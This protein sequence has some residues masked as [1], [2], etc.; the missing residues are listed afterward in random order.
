MIASAIGL[1]TVPL[2]G[3]L[4]DR[5]GRRPVYLFGAV[6]SLGFSFAYIPLLDTKSFV[7]ITVATIIGLNIGHDAMY[8]P[9]GAFFSESFGT[10]TRYTGASL[11]YQLGAPLGGGIAPLIAV[12]LL[13]VGPNGTFYIALY[14]AL[15]CVITIVGVLAARETYQIDIEEDATGRKIPGG[16]GGGGRHLSAATMTRPVPGGQLP[17]SALR[18]LPMSLRGSSSMKRTV[19]GS[20]VRR[21]QARDVVL[22]LPPGG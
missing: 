1:I 13:E 11:G 14:M 12:A 5:L 7:L 20:L 4:S 21:Q 22:E 15:C 10:R 8:G 3:A 17:K 19:R 9:Q 18:T 6:V 2:F 16:R